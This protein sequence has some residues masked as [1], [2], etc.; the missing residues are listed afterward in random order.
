M[1]L[2]KSIF[3]AHLFLLL[4]FQKAIFILI[5]LKCSIKEKFLV[6]ILRAGHFEAVKN[7]IARK[8]KLFL[9]GQAVFS[10]LHVSCLTCLL[11]ISHP[12][13]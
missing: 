9:S 3:R 1:R 6:L 4:T 11:S 2:F 7:F 10:M 12:L 5:Q 8:Q 13:Y